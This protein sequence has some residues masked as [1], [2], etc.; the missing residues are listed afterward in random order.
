MPKEITQD[1]QIGSDIQ[2]MVEQMAETSIQL[3]LET[4]RRNLEERTKNAKSRQEEIS[5]LART[6]VGLGLNKSTGTT[7]L[8]ALSAFYMPGATPIIGS[9]K[10]L[11]DETK[12]VTQVNYQDA[13]ERLRSAHDELLHSDRKTAERGEAFFRLMSDLERQKREAMRSIG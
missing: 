7:S 10:S 11:Y 1:F 3:S 5:K 4:S 2:N 8:M 12:Q 13:S 6:F 9:F